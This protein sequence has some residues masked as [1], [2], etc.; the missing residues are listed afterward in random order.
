M[1][2]KRHR[3]VSILI[4]TFNVVA[5][6]ANNSVSRGKLVTAVGIAER[7]RRRSADF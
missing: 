4:Y 6:Q 2:T 3:R 5:F 7:K 1:G